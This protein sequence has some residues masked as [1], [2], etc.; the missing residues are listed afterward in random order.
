MAH[1]LK[2]E[3]Y[4]IVVEPVPAV[5]PQWDLRTTRTW[6][7]GSC[8]RSLRNRHIPASLWSSPAPHSR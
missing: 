1:F 7:P 3:L 4:G 5:A 2:K 8:R 6:L